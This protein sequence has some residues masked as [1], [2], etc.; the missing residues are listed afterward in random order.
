MLIKEKVLETISDLPE[1][2]SLDE[3]ID[4]LILLEKIENGLHQVQDGKTYA[5]EEVKRK[6]KGWQK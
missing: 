3:I 1:T 4:R 2:F 6:L 5:Q